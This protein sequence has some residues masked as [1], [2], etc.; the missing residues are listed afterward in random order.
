M[1]EHPL[2]QI[3]DE[4]DRPIR[5]GTM[6]DAQMNGLWHRVA[7]IMVYCESTDE[8]LIQKV[9]PN[10]YYKGGLWCES[11]SGHVDEGE[12]YA[13]ATLRELAEEMG[14]SIE[15]TSIAEI[16]RYQTD[17]LVIIKGSERIFRRFHVLYLVR[18]KNKPDVQIN[19]DVAEF[20]WTNIEE[21]CQLDAS[22][23]VTDG[24][25]KTIA[26]LLKTTEK[27]RLAGS[28]AANRL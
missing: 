22:G 20:R 2:I 17:R 3:V 16:D 18:L 6:D 9:A 28:S 27:D 25:S 1:T 7:R 24:L 13:Q 15:E 26:L 23:L 19:D 11:A 14:V 10:E 5:G 12:S 4:A 21:L 8:Y